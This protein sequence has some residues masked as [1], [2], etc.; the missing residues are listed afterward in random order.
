MNIYQSIIVGCLIL[1]VVGCKHQ[2]ANSKVI[3]HQ[4]TIQQLEQKSAIANPPLDKSSMDVSYFPPEFTV[5]KMG[6]K[7]TGEPVARVI[8]SRPAVG[9]RTIF[10]DIVKYGK[11][12]RLGA[13]EATEI[14]FF[15]DITIE[16]KEIKKGRYTLYCV[17]FENYWELKL[18]SSLYT[19][20]LKIDPQYDL[21]SFK[22]NTE[23]L[24]FKM[25]FLSMQFIPDGNDMELQISWDSIKVSLPIKQ[26]I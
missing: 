12:W 1:S 7:V 19:W 22:V 10:G 2:P 9:G 3:R 8:Y 26:G 13:N 25:E 23:K 5:Q 6:G 18:N 24:P 17:P 20:G 15:K 11:P 14:E 16:N 4:E 21:Y